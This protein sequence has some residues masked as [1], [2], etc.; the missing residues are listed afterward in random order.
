MDLRYWFT[1]FTF[2]VISDLAFGESFDCMRNANYHPWVSIIVRGMQNLLYITVVRRH[3]PWVNT[4]LMRT[5]PNKVSAAHKQHA[6]LTKEIVAK[7][8]AWSTTRPDFIDAM[9][10]SGANG[11]EK[12]SLAEI[13]SNASLLI[14]AGSEPTS[15]A[16]TAAVY[17]LCLNPDVLTRLTKEVRS[18]F[19]T[20]AEID[21]V[22][23]L[24]LKYLT[25]VL[26]E[27]MR[28]Y[29][30]SPGSRPRKI[31]VNGDVIAGKLVPEGVSLLLVHCDCLSLF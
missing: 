20:E 26:D 21:I 9:L 3:L 29:P 14:V 12:L 19:N 4:V 6:L 27:A 22:S 23:V 8:L 10:N 5:M 16:L 7:R 11:D 1:Y 15:T 17:Y 31:R 13:E 25:A 18:N 30:P 28:I 24:Q 2:D